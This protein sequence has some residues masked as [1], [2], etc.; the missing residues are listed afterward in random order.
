MKNQKPKCSKW[1]G[2]AK[3]IADALSCAVVTTPKGA[4]VV[5]NRAIDAFSHGRTVKKPKLTKKQLAALAKG[6]AKAR[7]LGYLKPAKKRKS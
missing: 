5:V 3:A 7:K 6:R 4:K 1:T 2:I